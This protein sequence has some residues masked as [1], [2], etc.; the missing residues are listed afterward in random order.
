[1]KPNMGIRLAR[2]KQRVW[3]VLMFARIGWELSAMEKRK[4]T[5]EKCAECLCGMDLFT[6]KHIMVHGTKSKT[7]CGLCAAQLEA[8]GWKEIVRAK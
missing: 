4:T 6:G 7:V 2:I 1:M 3:L 8:K 5:T